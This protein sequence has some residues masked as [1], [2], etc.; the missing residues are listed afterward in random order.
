MTSITPTGTSTTTTPSAT[1]AAASASSGASAGLSG[2][3]QT[4]LK[5]LTTQLKNQDPLNPVEST[6]FA[7]Q[8]A[9]FSGVEQQVRTN[10]LLERMT[11]ANGMSGLGGVA[12]WVGMQA[13]VAAPVNFSGGPVTLSLSPDALAD[14]A[15]LVTY[16]ARNREV[17]REAV[18]PTATNLTWVGS[19]GSGGVLPAGTYRFALE[20]TRAGSVIATSAPETYATV[21]EVRAGGGDGPL[22]VL[23]TGATVRPKDVTALR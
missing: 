13:R 16:D 18:S 19:D 14:G 8:L 17:K 1:G 11:G 12:G 4:F 22:L 5:M 20:S 9:T 7:V 2:D 10:G 6:D 3:M 21:T 15:V 23:D